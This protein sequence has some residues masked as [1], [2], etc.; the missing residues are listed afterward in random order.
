M[1][2]TVLALVGGVALLAFAAD[3]FVLGAARVALVKNLSPVLVG[4]VIIGFGTSM[5]ELL[6]SALAAMRGNTEIAIG[7]IVGSNLANLSLLLG[8]GAMM[9]PLAVASRTVRREGLLTVGAVGVFALV[10]QGGGISRLEGFG[11]LLGLAVAMFAVSRRSPNDPLGSETESLVVAP[12]HALGT[13]IVRTALGMLGTIGGAQ[14]LLWGA[15]DLAERAGLAEG[16]VGVTLVAVGT[17]LPELVTVIQSARRRQ[18]D[19]IVG[20]LLGSN[21]F[22][23]LGVGGVV[24]L[25]AAAPVDAPALT[26]TGSTA[27]LIFA[28]IA[29]V[30]MHTGRV[31]NRLEGVV[32]MLGYLA[33]VPFLN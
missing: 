3:Q 24:G 4:I 21:L 6:V 33:L 16:F 31:V 17:S 2:P 20:N 10:V 18:T 8:V 14:L 27:A 32:L 1:I 26:V 15:V 7:N 29:V 11:L 19:L 25:A 22:N 23:A 12:A 5:P 30:A 28:V 13:E 9:V